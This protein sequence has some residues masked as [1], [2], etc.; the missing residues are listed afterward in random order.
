MLQFHL[1]MRKSNCVLIRIQIR[2]KNTH[3]E[4]SVVAKSMSVFRTKN[5]VLCVT[6]PVSKCRCM[7]DSLH[8]P[9][10]LSS[11]GFPASEKNQAYRVAMQ[12]FRRNGRNCPLKSQKKRAVYDDNFL[13]G[14][15]S[16]QTARNFTFHSIVLHSK[17]CFTVY[18][19]EEN[20]N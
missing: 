11:V 8:L 10:D 15:L 4:A 3:L 14:N 18:F 5:F 19:K 16:F 17:H 13:P 6:C 7:W 1:Q 9:I 20:Q 2:S 12:C